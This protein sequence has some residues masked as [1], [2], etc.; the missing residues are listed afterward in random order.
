[1]ILPALLLR[2]YLAT[3]LAFYV[4]LKS[5][6]YSFCRL[7]LR[8]YQLVCVIFANLLLKFGLLFRARRVG[9]YMLNVFTGGQLTSLFRW[10][11]FRR[12]RFN[13]GLRLNQL[14]LL[15]NKFLFFFLFRG[16][17]LRFLFPFR[18]GKPVYGLVYF[19]LSILRFGRD[20]YIYLSHW[21]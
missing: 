21:R 4:R 20:G 9:S 16:L 14:R 19:L 15:L 10:L 8:L 3:V 1:M 5:S 7:I 18:I 13:F 17:L 2:F 12:L 6:W 11:L